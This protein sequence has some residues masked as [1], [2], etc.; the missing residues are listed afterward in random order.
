MGSMVYLKN[1][2]TL[3]IDTSKCTGCGMCLDVC[4]HNVFK[5]NGKA[6]MIVDRDACMECGACSKNCPAGALQVQSGVGCA[7]AVING[8]LGRNGGECCCGPQTDGTDSVKSGGA[9]CS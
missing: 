3:G 6:V 9:C 8:M 4:P 5:M 7:A 2:A 1:V